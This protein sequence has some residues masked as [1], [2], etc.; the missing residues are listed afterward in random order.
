MTRG[1][2]PT[3]T[4]KCVKNTEI[5]EAMKKADKIK[6]SAADMNKSPNKKNDSGL[7]ESKLCKQKSRKVS[8]F[9]FSVFKFSL[10][11]LLPPKVLTIYRCTDLTKYKWLFSLVHPFWEK[12]FE[13]FTFL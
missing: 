8:L 13:K 11:F 4:C 10:F 7:R 5:F 9:I 12:P 6:S 2:Q 1:L 3:R